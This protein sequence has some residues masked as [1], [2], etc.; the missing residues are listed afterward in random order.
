MRLLALVESADHVCHRYRIKAFEPALSR[1]GWSIDA[2]ALD[3]S[4]WFRA[5]QLRSAAQYDAVILQRRL[6]S[7]WQF[8]ILRRQ[9][10]RLIY[11]I[12][13]AVFMRDSYAAKGT[14]SRS[15]LAR[16]WATIYCSDAIVVGNPYLQQQTASYV[17]HE[18]VVMIPT[19]VD[20]EAYPQADHRQRF[21]EDVTRLVWIGQQSTLPSLNLAGD[22]L[23]AASRSTPNLEL[24]VVCDRFPQIPGV[25]VEQRPWSS[26]T[27]AA[28][29]ARCDIGLSWLP[30][31]PWSRGKCGLKVLQYMAAGLPVV[32]NPVGM[33]LSMVE[34]G[35]TGFI[36]ETPEEWAEAIVRLSANPELR[37]QMG[38]VARRRVYQEYSIPAWEDRF[39]E[40]VQGVA[41]HRGEQGGFRASRSKS[42]KE[43]SVLGAGA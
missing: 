25:R 11:D 6:L 23:A 33:N 9:A 28:E 36:A 13:D 34:H 3:R 35:R 22:S 43:P 18:K 1:A 39:V 19:C 15:R 16:F 5:K 42:S 27:E 21:S 40:V 30:D 26:A 2:V 12:D 38:N 24:A 29:L 17:D 20:P 41:G 8:A 37:A 14:Y 7:L 4:S 32:A 10:R 31:D